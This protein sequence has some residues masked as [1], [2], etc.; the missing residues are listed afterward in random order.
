MNSRLYTGQ[1]MHER[2]EPVPHRFEYPLYLY[3]L[4]LDELPALDRHVRGFG[5]NHFNLVS[6]RD[7]HYLQGAG[8]IRER[9][10]PY[11]RER[12]CDDGIARID[13]VTMA[14]MLGYCF[15]PVSF[16]Y[17]LRA[18]GSLRCAVAEVNNT[19]NERHVYVLDKPLSAPGVWPV[20]Y[21]Q[22]KQ[23]HVSP[24]NDMRG[25]YELSFGRPCASLQVGVTL[26][27]DERKIMAAW[28]TGQ[29]VLLDSRTLWKT[30]LRYPLTAAL[31]FPRIVREAAT[32][33]FRKKIKVHR[34]PNPS[35]HLTIA[36]APP[37]WM[38]RLY[39]KGVLAFLERMQVGD[40]TLRLP[41][42]S[43]RRFGRPGTGRSQALTIYNYEFFRRVARGG[44]VGFGES[45]VAGEWECDDL[46]ELLRLM[47]DNAPFLDSNALGRGSIARFRDRLLH[48]RR[49]NTLRGSRRNIEA[50]YDYGNDFFSEFLDHE[51]WLYSC[52][53]Y[54]TEGETLEQAQRNKISAVNALA[55][56][57]PGDHLLEIGC[58]WGGYAVETVRQTG[59]RLTG[60]TLSHEQ[61]KLAQ[62]RVFEAGLDDKICLEIRDYRD[63]TGCY[64]AIVSIEMLEA[65]GHEYYGAFFSACA[66]V[67][68]PGGRL[69]IQV[70]TI[71]NE[72]YETYRQNP[73]WI[74]KHIFPGG[75]LPSLGILK[76]AA[77]DAGFILET[78]NSIGPHYAT[79]L[80]EWQRRF[81]A[82]HDRLL[83]LGYPDEEQRKWRYYFSYCEAGF[84]AGYIDDYHLVFTRPNV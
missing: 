58:G 32:L 10:M 41:D 54:R 13:V 15:N 4:D 27:R 60:I 62:Q 49:R 61:L 80:N 17:C 66:R 35:H 31:S 65:V 21:R 12:N 36:T 29:A 37:S 22:E 20:V 64:D 83:A 19:F 77:R 75:L 39:T 43:V 45:Y 8:S 34:K 82:A 47:I 1:V 57:G 50:H 38:Q 46:T 11:L 51:T 81:I 24:F 79:T 9:V 18:D 2:F 42:G 71:P 30:I 33:Y 69:V 28:F 44:D 52:A 72:R 78:A 14:R 5:Y 76:A 23:F 74:Q 3:A 59:C 68:K 70:I 25:W 55:R 67:L 26:F 40:L 7:T 73:D 56:P 84:A 63:V 53:I 16:Y 6:I 48:G